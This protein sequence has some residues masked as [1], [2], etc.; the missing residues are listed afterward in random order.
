MSGP[1]KTNMK[2]V[3]Y[4]FL[5]LIKNI[6]INNVKTNNHNNKLPS[7]FPQVPAIL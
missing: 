2:P 3:Y 1:M 4:N 6:E 7:W 5:D